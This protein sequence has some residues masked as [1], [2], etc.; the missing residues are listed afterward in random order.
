[1][2]NLHL[3]GALVMRSNLATGMAY[4]PLKK[5]RYA[6]AVEKEPPPSELIGLVVEGHLAQPLPNREREIVQ[7]HLNSQSTLDVPDPTPVGQRFF[8]SSALLNPRSHSLD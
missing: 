3:A 1:M 8:Y 5:T 2:K 6:D 4:W 7:K